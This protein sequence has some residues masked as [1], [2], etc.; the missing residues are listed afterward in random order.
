MD[1]LARCMSGT[2]ELLEAA[3]L[4]RKARAKSGRNRRRAPRDVR[5]RSRVARLVP[6]KTHR[7]GVRGRELKG[8]ISQSSA[9][10]RLIRG[11]VAPPARRVQ[12]YGLDHLREEHPPKS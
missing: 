7:A 5:H 3:R 6:R 1:T 8:P 12:Q 9:S 11:P 4:V 2:S 10:S